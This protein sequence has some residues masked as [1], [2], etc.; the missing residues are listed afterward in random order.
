MKT[1]DCLHQNIEGERYSFQTLK[2]WVLGVRLK[3]AHILQHSKHK[4]KQGFTTIVALQLFTS[5]IQR[6]TVR[7]G[8]SRLPYNF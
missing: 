8:L 7:P 2:N 5:S 1:C 4:V 6:G 3:L